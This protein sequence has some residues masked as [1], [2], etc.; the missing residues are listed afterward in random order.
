MEISE[1]L[2][3]HLPAVG[4]EQQV[5]G[6][7]AE[8]EVSILQILIQHLP[9]LALSVYKQIPRIMATARITMRE[10]FF[11][12]FLDLLGKLMLLTGICSSSLRYLARFADYVDFPERSNPSNTMKAPRLRME[13]P[14]LITS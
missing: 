8:L 4:S 14:L 10:M 2:L 13:V 3:S 7:V 1:D 5:N 9:A 11:I 6:L 12:A